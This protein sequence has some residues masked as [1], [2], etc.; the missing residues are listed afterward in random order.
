LPTIRVTTLTSS[1]PAG[2]RRAGKSTL[3]QILCRSSSPRG[4][5]P[6]SFSSWGVLNA[7]A[8]RIT[9]RRRYLQP[10]WRIRAQGKDRSVQMAARQIFRRRS[11]D[12]SYSRSSTRLR[13]HAYG[14]RAPRAGRCTRRNVFAAATTAARLRGQRHD[15]ETPSPLCRTSCQS[16]GSSSQRGGPARATPG[17][18]AWRTI[19]AAS[20]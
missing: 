2:F 11:R 1:G 7:P 20:P 4:P 5:M 8:H 6:E 14:R 19:R 17:D 15:A 10:L 3:H 16:L 9:S 18:R 12:G 13:A